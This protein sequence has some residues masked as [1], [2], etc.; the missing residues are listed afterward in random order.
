M[1]ERL[2]WPDLFILGGGVSKKHEQFLPY[3]T[4]EAEVLPAKV[5]NNAGI[6]GSA[7]AAQSLLANN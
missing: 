1:L 5:V 4:V 7:L 2:L 3:L 6:V